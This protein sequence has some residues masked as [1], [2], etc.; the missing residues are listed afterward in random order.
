MTPDE[1][2]AESPLGHA[3]FSTVAAMLSEHDDV[4]VKTT[5]S[6]IAFQRRRGFAYIWLP[7]MY[8]ARP[9]AEVVLSIALRRRI[10]SRRF[11][12][13]AHPSPGV[14]QHHLEVRG[15]D[16]LDAEVRDWLATAYESAG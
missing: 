10:A 5:K 11:K 8:L 12:E 2:L 4:T 9:N 16:D 1:F 14:W 13:I 15:V 6:Q 3:V 7:G